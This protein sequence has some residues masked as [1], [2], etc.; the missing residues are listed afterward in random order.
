METT[1]NQP[2][3]TSKRHNWTLAAIFAL[4][5]AGFVAYT[6]EKSPVEKTVPGEALVHLFQTE[7]MV[8]NGE[9]F[10]NSTITFLK[11]NSKESVVIDSVLIPE[12]ISGSREFNTPLLTAV[13]FK[14]DSLYYVSNADLQYLTDGTKRLV[15]PLT[16][17]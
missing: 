4:C 15:V 7:P 11:A 14:T 3:K 13:L 10:L 12:K 9:K 6:W 5:V 16:V 8:I 1:E 17:D 2:E